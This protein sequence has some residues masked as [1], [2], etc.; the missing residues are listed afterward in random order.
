[1]IRPIKTEA[2]YEWPLA[3]IERLFDTEHDTPD[4]DRLDVLITLVEA[5]E[6]EHYSILL[7]DS[8]EMHEVT[9]VRR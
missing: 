8:I 1:M 9:T 2:D 7:P 5:Y 3:E 4:S 6:N